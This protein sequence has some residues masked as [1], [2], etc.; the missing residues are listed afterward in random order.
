[1]AESGAEIFIKR[2]EIIS[3][4]GPYLQDYY[5]EI[6][7]NRESAGILY[8]PSVSCECSSKNEWKNVFYE[9][10]KERR[11]RDLETG[12]S[13][14]GPHRDDIRFLLNQK[15]SKT[16][17]SQGQCRSIVLSLKLS[18]V[19]CLEHFRQDKMIFLIDDALSELDQDRTSRVLP[20]IENKGQVFIATPVL[21]SPM[22]KTLLR[23]KVKDGTVT[24]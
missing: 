11:N 6:S 17:G 21:N 22:K 9:L 18:S 13:T 20:L 24:I 19:S 4:L 1:M 3:F 8:E 14:V 7:G 5:K 12:F 16:Y 15:P 10:L 2:K 23:C